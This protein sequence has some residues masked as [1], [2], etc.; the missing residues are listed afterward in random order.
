MCLECIRTSDKSKYTGVGLI[1]VS[2]VQCMFCFEICTP[3]GRGG[4]KG[5]YKF[6]NKVHRTLDPM[7]SST[8]LRRYLVHN[9]RQPRKRREG[10]LP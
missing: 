9:A 8:L 3:E 4:E 2:K 10:A 7:I 6:Q 5:R 1:L